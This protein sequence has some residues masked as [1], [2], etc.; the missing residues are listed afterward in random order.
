MLADHSR[1]HDAAGHDLSA[2]TQVQV[3]S[4]VLRATV[5]SRQVQRLAQGC[6]RTPYVV[7][8]PVHDNSTAVNDP[9]NSLFTPPS[10]DRYQKQSKWILNAFPF[11]GRL[12]QKTGSRNLPLGGTSA[13][14]ARGSGQS[15]LARCACG[16]FTAS[17][18]RG[19]YRTPACALAL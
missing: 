13:T 1:V 14:E 3:D 9:T 11:S 10:S 12:L 15:R 8:T 6:R 5:P 16:M 17:R 7:R 19:R 2:H 18:H 4:P